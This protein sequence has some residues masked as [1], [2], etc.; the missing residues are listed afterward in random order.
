VPRCSAALT[1]QPSERSSCGH[2]NSST[3]SPVEHMSVAIV[4][5]STAYLPA[6]D[7]ALAAPG[8]PLRVVPMQVVIAGEAFAEDEIDPERISQALRD[9]EIVTTAGPNPES[10]LKSYRSLAHEGATEIVSIH[11]SSH[12]S[13]TYSSALIA[14]EMSPVPVRVIDSGTVG[15]ALGFAA[16]AGL[17]AAG[18]GASLEQVAEVVGTT[19]RD[20]RQFFY[21]D[22]LEHLRRGGR[23][24]VG[25]ALIGQALSVKPLLTVR[26][27]RVEPAERVRTSA[28]ALS[29]LEDL[30]V[31]SARSIT[32]ARVD[33]AVHHLD[34]A[35]RGGALAARINERLGD[36]LA[37]P[38]V[39]TQI[40]AAVGA[41]V[42]PGVVAIVVAPHVD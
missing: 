15:M 10:L 28:R 18:S 1:D 42:G 7:A 41:H 25:Q 26:G 35:E 6:S 33:A 14:A 17:R 39:M 38:T 31:E 3:S 16:M 23:I 12:M 20:S 29:R 13:G 30:A 40:G 19:A 4:T 36:R 8:S 5:D 24:N 11:I 2:P 37:R 27:G 21:V 9:W 22:T 32:T 34:S